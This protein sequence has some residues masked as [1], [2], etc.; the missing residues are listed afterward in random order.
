MGTVKSSA[1]TPTANIGL[2][3]TP[4]QVPAMLV[5]AMFKLTSASVKFA[6]VKMPVLLL[7]RV[8]VRVLM[9]PLPMLDG[10]KAFA[11][12]GGVIGGVVKLVVSAA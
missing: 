8:N 6:W 5:E 1:L 7:P 3:V 12:V 4:A 11:M 10:L 2:L 9:S